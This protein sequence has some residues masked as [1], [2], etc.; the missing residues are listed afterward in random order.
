MKTAVM[1]FWWYLGL[2]L[3]AIGFS[4]IHFVNLFG[5]FMPALASYLPGSLFWL[6]LGRLITGEQKE[7]PTTF[8]IKTK[9]L[10]MI[11]L[12]AGI[13]LSVFLVLANRT[14]A[15]SVAV[16]M[17]LAGA[18]LMLPVRAAEAQTS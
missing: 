15:A 14:D 16:L 6:L 5:A 17:A 1:R 18:D 11:L 9:S 13:V 8:G 7:S 3:I 4:R 2:V 12:F 10:G